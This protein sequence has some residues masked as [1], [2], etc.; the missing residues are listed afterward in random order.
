MH[1]EGDADVV[2]AAALTS[3]PADPT[4]RVPGGE[5]GLDVLQRFDC[6]VDEAVRSG[7]QTV[8]MIIH[9]VAIRV[10]L[11]SRPANVTVEDIQQRELDKPAS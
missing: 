7:A 9:G 4:T 6:V 3:W 5:S 8:A 1:T 11:A 10:W 2:T